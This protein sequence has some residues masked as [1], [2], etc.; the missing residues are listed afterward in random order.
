[1]PLPVSEQGGDDVVDHQGEHEDGHMKEQEDED[2]GPTSGDESPAAGEESTEEK[3]EGDHDP[4]FVELW[5]IMRQCRTQP[6]VILDCYMA[7]IDTID[8]TM[9]G[10]TEQLFNRLEQPKSV[11]RPCQNTCV[12]LD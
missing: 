9:N 8:E 2:D 7:Y 10:L 5:T 1:M 3:L 4:G 6:R 11:L 12:S